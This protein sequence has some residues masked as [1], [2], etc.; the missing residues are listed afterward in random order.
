MPIFRVPF[1]VSWA[2]VGALVAKKIMLKSAI[3]LHEN[4]LSSVLFLNQYLDKFISRLCLLWRGPRQ[5]GVCSAVYSAFPHS[6][7]HSDV[8]CSF[9][10]APVPF[11][12][13]TWTWKTSIARFMRHR[14]M[15]N[16]KILLRTHKTQASRILYMFAVSCACRETTLAAI[17]GRQHRQLQL[18]A[19]CLYKYS[20]PLH[21]RLFVCS[22]L[23]IFIGVSARKHG[24]TNDMFAQ[25]K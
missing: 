10:F 18:M 1:V 19:Y 7:I 3:N 23:H 25:L 12:G 24:R 22:L 16:C 15:E 13:L 20:F 11:A 4:S 2:F 21:V 6:L 14:P 9:P 5:N 8:F 17:N